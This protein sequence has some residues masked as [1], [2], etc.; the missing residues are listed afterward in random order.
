MQVDISVVILLA[1]SSFYK[2]ENSTIGCSEN[3]VACIAHEGNLVEYVGGVSDVAE[4]RQLCNDEDSCQFLT[5]YDATSFPWRESCFLLSDCEDK[6]P[7]TDCLSEPRFCYQSC[8]F[9]Y[10]GA[11]DNNVIDLIPDVDSDLECR[12][13]CLAVRECSHYTYFGDRGQCYLLSSLLEPI[14]YCD[15][16]VTGPDVCTDDDRCLFLQN[17]TLQKSFMFTDTEE[18]INGHLLADDHCQVRLFL[19][20]GGG[21]YSGHTY[22]GGGSGYLKYSS[23][24]LNEVKSIQIEVGDQ[25]ETST[26]TMDGVTLEAGPGESDRTDGTIRYGGNGYSGG[27]SVSCECNGGS[28]GGDGGGDG[29]THIGGKGTG[30]KLSSFPM[31]TFILSPGVGGQYYGSSFGGGGGGVLVNGAGPQEWNVH[32]GQG[33]GGGG[34]HYSSDSK[35][36]VEIGLRGVILLEMVP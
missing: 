35:E 5:Y 20:G 23:I 2:C 21:K 22:G 8:I 28:D 1:L 31:D 32:Q 36:Y 33:F 10:T 30:E 13:S 18:I 16:C 11:I 34:C 19:V 15:N 6:E 17:G 9:P 27:G 3:N 4:C 14:N 12:N 29:D 7:C 26:V 24:T 25:G